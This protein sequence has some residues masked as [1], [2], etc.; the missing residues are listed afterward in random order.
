MSKIV[1]YLLCISE[2]FTLN[3]HKFCVWI[4]HPYRLTIEHEH[5]A[6]I[7][8]K[9]A[10]ALIY[11][12]K[13]HSYIP[14][15]DYKLKNDTTLLLYIADPLPLGEALFLLWGKNKLPVYARK[16]VRTAWFDEHYAAS[17]AKLGAIT[18]VYKTR[19][20]LWAPTAVSVQLKVENDS[21]KM[22]RSN[23][24]VWTRTVDEN[25][26][27]RAYHYIVN[28]NGKEIEVNDPYAKASLANSQR[29][30]VVDFTKTRQM[31]YEAPETALEETIIYELHVRDATIHQDSGVKHKGKYKG[32]TEKNTKTNDG[33]T[34]GLAYIKELGVTHLQLLPINDFARVNEVNP[35][36]Y[37]WGYDPLFFQ[38]PEGS[39]ASDARKPMTRINEVKEMIDTFHEVS[40]SIILDVVY[41]HVYIREQST[42]EQI[43][44][45]YYFRYDERTDQ[46]SN[47]TG[48][49]NDLATERV[50]VRKFILDTIDLWLSEYRVDGFRFDLMGVM[51]IKTMQAIKKRC[52]REK[53]PIMLLGEGWDLPTALDHNEKA[54]SQQ[55]H[56]LQ[57]IRFFNDY[58]RN[59]IKGTSYEKVNDGYVNGRGKN[60]A[61]LPTLLTGSAIEQFGPPFV[62]HVSQ[63][64]NYVECH[65]NYTLW[66]Q[67]KIT[68]ERAP[69]KTRKK[70]H[71]LAT[72]ITLLSLGIPFIHAGQEFFRTKGGDDNSYI[73]GDNVNQ[74][75][76]RRRAKEVDAIQFVKQL[77]ALRKQH[78]VF[79]LTSHDDIVKQFHPIKTPNPTFGFVLLASESDIVVYINPTEKTFTKVRLPSPGL[80]KR[81]V[82]NDEN[83]ATEKEQITTNTIK[84]YPYELIVFT[85]NR[86]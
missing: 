71:Q 39:Y 26:H 10:A 35:T 15:K 3:K 17:E 77:I 4:D 16:I 33:Y 49:G 58:F 5:A 69:E 21:Y 24:G 53:R 34:T 28:V 40:L 44:P 67:L 81:Q 20:S 32:L 54:T 63:T 80:W 13:N 43:V 37:N 23:H 46:P 29:S 62:S 55:S 47:G 51:D 6:T 76:W 36:S 59:M 68:N 86:V 70:I 9:W 72:G 38:L 31:N 83:R 82:T 27:N 45:G 74:L 12:E 61:H 52:K 2:E 22:N 8:N 56:R 64:I 57:G 50:M 11:W 48:V 25:L 84:L 1:H 65:D 60:R 30:V 73:S 85:K 14:I 7:I 19:F 42:F 41:N 66:D 78:D 75:D 18:T 79:Q